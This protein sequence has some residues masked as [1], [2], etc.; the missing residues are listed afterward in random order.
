MS[1]MEKYSNAMWAQILGSFKAKE[2]AEYRRQFNVFD[3]S[4]NGKI[5]AAELGALVKS[6]GMHMS[7]EDIVDMVKVCDFDQ[8][9]T[10]A[11]NEFLQMVFAVN[12][13]EGHAQFAEIYKKATGADHTP[14]EKMPLTYS[15]EEV[16]AILKE[17]TWFNEAEANAKTSEPETGDYPR[18]VWTEELY[19]VG[20]PHIDAQHQKLFQ[21]VDDLETILRK[22]GNDDQVANA[23]DELLAYA[24]YHFTSEEVEMEKYDYPLKGAHGKIHQA[25][26]EKMIAAVN[27][28]KFKLAENVEDLV[29]RRVIWETIYFLRNWLIN[30]IQ[31][32]DTAF[33]K[34][35]K[36]AREKL[37]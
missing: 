8:S 20:Y 25:F 3:T 32:E 30:H 17:F 2:L 15:H 14:W 10:I 31:K 19:G 23:L 11:F 21:I 12:F 35:C 36:E 6:L 9:G 1:T 5:E 27:D 33:G 34:Y 16:E 24:D 13:G 28:L 26:K 18:F 37:S 29:D 22:G 4:K 7:D